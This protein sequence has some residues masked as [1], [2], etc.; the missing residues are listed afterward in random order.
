MRVVF[1]YRSG[2][3]Q[4]GKVL[5]YVREYKMRHPDIE[6]EL[7][8]LQTIQGAE[9]AKLYSIY[10]YPAILAISRDGSLMQLWQDERLPLMQDL[11]AY[12]YAF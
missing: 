1:L 8:D 4:E 11:D 12:A 9:L 5:D 6:P 10:S 7:M 2:T 3:E